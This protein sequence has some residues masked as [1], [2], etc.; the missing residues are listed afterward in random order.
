[1]VNISKLLS[2]PESKTMEFKQDLSSLKPIL[3]TLVAFANTAG[4]T[5]LVGR[6]DGGKPSGVM[7]VFRAEEKLAN[8]ISDSIHPPLMPEIEI[9]SH[10]K[11]SFLLVRVPFWRGP[12]YI[13]SEGPI[14]GVYI[15]LGSTNSPAGPEI[16]DELKR[17]ISNISF[18][19][20]PFPMVDSSGLNMEKIEQAFAR[21]GQKITKNKLE[22]LGILVPYSGKKVCSVGGLILFGQDHLRMQHFPNSEV[23]CARFRDTTR[24]TFIDQYDVTGSILDAMDEVPKFINRNT[25]L[26]A[27]IES[28]H[29]KDIPEYSPIAIREV[30]TNAFV[31]ADYSVRG[32]NPK[33]A[34]FSNRLEIESPGMF[35]F[36][37]TLEDFISGI[38]HVRNKVITRVFREL[39]IMEEWGTGYKRIKNI[40]QKES[41]IT[42]EWN[43]QGIAI[44][45]TFKPH[46]A[47]K[48]PKVNYSS[49]RPKKLSDR[50]HEI[51]NLLQE[52]KK[53]TSKEIF[54]KLNL[55]ISERTLRLDL[56]QLKKLK[57]LKK[58]GNGPSSSWTLEK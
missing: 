6:E 43:E 11:K 34:I 15:R 48:E 33:I 13:K 9:L 57:L 4:G 19:Q 5:L 53:L 14:N 54:D 41:Y 25:R 1:M 39:K 55:K 18:D 46:A 23:R 21:V 37:Y 52:I 32:M 8:A 2:K 49:S 44:R 50:Q 16:L 29:R 51:L 20:L 26:A 7:D 22:T 45:V 36:G 40:C 28:I 30:L 31:H 12:F 3:K 27:K 17:S 56:L 10:E 58:N 24:C 35:P 47:T 38:S 42:P